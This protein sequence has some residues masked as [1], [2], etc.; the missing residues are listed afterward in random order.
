MANPRIETENINL[1]G[2][3]S[4]VEFLPKEQLNTH[5]KNYLSHMTKQLFTHGRI[6]GNVYVYMEDGEKGLWGYVGRELGDM[7][8]R[9][10]R[11]R[12]DMYGYGFS[13]IPFGH[14]LSIS[15][16]KLSDNPQVRIAMKIV[17]AEHKKLEQEIKEYF[18]Y[19]SAGTGIDIWSISL[20]V[21]ML[22]DLQD[23]AGFKFYGGTDDHHVI[24]ALYK[25][26]G[27]AFYQLKYPRA[28]PLAYDLTKKRQRFAE[29]VRNTHETQINLQLI[30]NGKGNYTPPPSFITGVHSDLVEDFQF[31]QLVLSKASRFDQLYK[32]DSVSKPPLTS[33]TGDEEHHFVEDYGILEASLF[34]EAIGDKRG[35]LRFGYDIQ[36]CAD[37]GERVIVATD[38]P[39]QSRACFTASF[40][41]VPVRKQQLLSHYFERSV[42]T[43]GIDSFIGQYLPLKNFEQLFD[44]NVYNALL[45]FLDLNLPYHLPSNSIK[46]K[47]E[48]QTNCDNKNHKSE[49]LVAGFGR[50]LMQS[51]RI[52]KLMTDYLLTTKGMYE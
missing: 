27:Y 16:V 24:E 9:I 51:T 32:V 42:I 28:K 33:P 30:L 47:Y 39:G 13:I 48:L 26:I 37:C 3:E 49:L 5:Y 17:D 22:F 11:Q 14:A 44:E 35:I 6:G 21:Y 23:N 20:P 8:G 12:E 43:G 10:L 36:Y 41:P 52:D 40:H 46:G 45:S 2:G 15:A 4:K 1:D 7:C 29:K 34:S 31:L 25:G 18:G 19:F 38:I 50:S